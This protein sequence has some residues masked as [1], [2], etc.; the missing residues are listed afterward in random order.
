MRNTAQL[1]VEGRQ[2]LGGN[3][4]NLRGR[5]TCLQPDQRVLR[6]WVFFFSHLPILGKSVRCGLEI[7]RPHRDGG[8]GDGFRY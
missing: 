1:L 7:L 6:Q 2:Q 4:A 5:R 8:I 3:A